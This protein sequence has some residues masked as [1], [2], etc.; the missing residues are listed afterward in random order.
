MAIRATD[1]SG[2][3]RT[4]LGSVA[5]FAKWPSD[6]F[7]DLC[8]AAQLWRFAKGETL[9]RFGEPVP[10]LIVLAR[11]SL[12]NVRFYP[13]GKRMATA[14][15]KPGWPVGMLPAWDELDCAYDGVARTDCLVIIIPGKML[16]SLF[17]ND[18]ERMAEL[19]DF[20]CAQIRQDTESLLARCISSQR[21][22]LAKYLAYLCRPSV[23][24]TREDP[25]AVDP[26][27]TDVTQDE[28]AAMMAASR[29]TV[30][31]LM[32]GLERDG[33][34]KRRG[35][36]VEIVNFRR[37]LAVMEEDEPIP[38]LWRAQILAWHERLASRAGQTGRPSRDAVH[39]ESDLVAG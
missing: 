8:A 5:L 27:A 38:P 28:L 3:T 7:N 32:K 14:I 29:Q 11:G 22:F 30:N 19:A 24:V 9:Y 2:L 34:L 4:V 37:L 13:N 15:L 26:V 25:T 17:R 31:R 6:A 16:R 33:V 21:S 18:A 10:G 1:T 20:F 36:L 35:A 12:L 39:R 23:F